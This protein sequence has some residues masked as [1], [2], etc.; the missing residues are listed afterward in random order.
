MNHDVNNGR[1][2]ASILAD[3][4]DEL[5][6]FI[7]T[8][9]SLFRT[10][11]GEKMAMVKRAA[12]VAAMALVLLGTAYV[13]FTLALVGVVLALL[14]ANPWRWCFA[15]LAVGVLWAILGVA[16]AMMAKRKLALKEL[17]P[18]RTI[19]VLKGDGV[20]IQ[21]EVKNQI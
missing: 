14:P 10:E 13:L 20:W 7:Q 2:I 8:R 12:P 21:S 4:K 9:V 1:T 6:Q 3:T 15:F 16:A 19:G 11:L 18:N 17:M 5:K